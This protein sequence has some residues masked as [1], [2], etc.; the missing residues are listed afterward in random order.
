M[1][2]ISQEKM[3]ECLHLYM[4]ND[5]LRRKCVD[6]DLKFINMHHSQ[7]RLL[8]HLSHTKE[9]QNQT[10][11]AKKFEVSQ[12]AIGV[13]LRKLESNG[14]IKKEVQQNDN[15]FNKILITEKGNELIKKSR[16][17]FDEMDKYIFKDFTEKEIDDLTFLLKKMRKNLNEKE[18]EQND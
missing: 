7:H 17:T 13:S 18:C 9:I 5:R 16:E 1:A 15:R 4:S 11:I 3:K 6:R 8:M 10:D 14:Y 2:D 12:A